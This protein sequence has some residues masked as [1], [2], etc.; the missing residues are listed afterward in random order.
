[1]KQSVILPRIRLTKIKG[2]GRAIIPVAAI[3]GIEEDKLE[4]CT[5]VC[6]FDGFWYEVSNSIEEVDAKIEEAEFGAS[7]KMSQGKAPASGAKPQEPQFP[8]KKIVKK[9][10][11]AAVDKSPR[12]MADIARAEAQSGKA[13]PCE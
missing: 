10:A 9:T 4:K 6:T 3:S 11:S 13:T 5:R 8:Q 2:K 7:G 12:R 1:M